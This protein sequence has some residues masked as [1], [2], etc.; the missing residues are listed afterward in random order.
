MTF[1]QHH[2]SKIVLEAELEHQPLLM[3]EKVLEDVVQLEEARSPLI[4]EVIYS[5]YSR[6]T[7]E[8]KCF[9]I[10]AGRNKCQCRCY[11]SSN[12]CRRS[13]GRLQSND[14]EFNDNTASASQIC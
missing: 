12:I 14:I 11:N 3:P 4:A 10:V 9:C 8:L 1:A 7:S 5:I 6:T 13:F 2:F